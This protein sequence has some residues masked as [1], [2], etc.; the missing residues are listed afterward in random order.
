MRSL[1]TGLP[2]T[3]SA[4]VKYEG[5]R[6]CTDETRAGKRSPSTGQRIPSAAGFSTAFTTAAES[7][8]AAPIGA[9]TAIGGFTASTE[10][11]ATAAGA[12]ICGAGA[13]AG[14]TASASG[15]SAAAGA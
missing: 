2:S 3:A 13:A 8:L 9:A 11:A 4:T 10:T 15:A 12:A 7:T 1:S 6:S 14:F 5:A